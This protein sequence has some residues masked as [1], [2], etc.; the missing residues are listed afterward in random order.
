MSNKPN[1]ISRPEF[2][3]I[4]TRFNKLPDSFMGPPSLDSLGIPVRSSVPFN[5]KE[6]LLHMPIRGEYGAGLSEGSLGLFKALL[7]SESMRPV[8]DHFDEFSPHYNEWSQ[9]IIEA[10]SEPFETFHNRGWRELELD[11]NLRAYSLIAEKAN[12][13]SELLGQ[14]IINGPGFIKDVSGF[15]QDSELPRLLLKLMS[16]TTSCRWP[17]VLYRCCYEPGSSNISSLEADDVRRAESYLVLKEVN[18]KKKLPDEPIRDDSSLSGLAGINPI[19]LKAG[20][21]VVKQA[22]KPND[23]FSEDSN[24]GSEYKPRKIDHHENNS[25]TDQGVAPPTFAP[26][27]IDLQGGYAM[28]KGSNH[29]V[30]LKEA[31]YQM[32]RISYRQGRNLNHIEEKVKGRDSGFWLPAK[33]WAVILGAAFPGYNVRG[34]K[35]NRYR[36]TN[37]AI[38]AARK[39]AIRHMESG[40][41]S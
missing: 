4:D 7:A 34:D 30:F 2:F 6:G 37:L 27:R 32:V 9:L 8:W 33:L 5:M 11:H 38:Q 25:F 1:R 21:R 36:S 40:R 24:L 26:P 19:I 20:N 18:R 14:P 16:L 22:F 41:D 12:E 29:T 3:Y 13:L 23:D 15:S 35:S 17:D 31:V 28:K 10:L 39:A